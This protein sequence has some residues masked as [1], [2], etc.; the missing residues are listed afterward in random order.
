MK[1]SQFKKERAMKNKVYS[2]HAQEA[3]DKHIKEI[4]RLTGL[5]TT[6]MGKYRSLKR[7]HWGY[8]GDLCRV[9]E[10]LA[11]AWKFIAATSD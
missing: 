4:E 2:V 9:E 5:I 11:D 3:V 7:A 8:V 10:L 1:S 6:E